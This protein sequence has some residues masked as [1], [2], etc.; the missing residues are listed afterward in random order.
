MPSHRAG[1]LLAAVVVGVCLP[2][3]FAAPAA[4]DVVSDVQA[5][6]HV[7]T[8]Q[9]Y[10]SGVAV[11]DL[12]T[13][14]YSGG[15]EDTA[16]FASESVAKVLI[17]TQLLATGQM[18][19]ATEATAY[20]M[21]TQSDDDAASALYGLAGGD[22]VINLVAA[23]YQIPLLGTPPDQSGWWGNTEITA[24]GMVYLYA[25]IARDPSVGPWLMNAMA[26]ASEYGADGT[27]Q[28]FGIPSATTGAAIKQGWGDDG[29]DSPN[30]VFNSTGFVDNDEY[31]V[32]ILTDGSPWTYGAAISSVVTQ[33]AQA[34][35]PGGRIDNPADHDPVLSPVTVTASG[36][37]VHL[38]GTAVDPDAPSA[39][40]PVRVT[41]GGRTIVTTT[42]TAATRR[43]NADFAASDGTHTYTVTVGNLSD[44]TAVSHATAPVSI[45]GDP[46][47][48]VNAV[49]GGSGT[50]TIDGQEADPNSPEP[51]L[52]IGVA[53]AQPIV[54]STDDPA[55]QITVPASAGIHEVTVTYLHSSDA[56]N[57]TEGTWAV[58]VGTT[59]R[60]TR[61]LDASAIAALPTL[62][63]GFV[64]GYRWLRRT[65]R[66]ANSSERAT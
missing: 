11:L 50:I 6:A 17:A 44:G 63:L 64:M 48:I 33:Q 28:F 58:T 14:A 15:G 7:A 54:R 10:R 49:T 62:L 57:V 19:G 2:L 59:A 65:R 35:M 38:T 53:G 43:F 45:D 9:G 32:A 20:E 30:A 34:L 27:Y 42:T 66:R 36:N 23:R 56:Q 39:S 5:A 16:P 24:K 55:Y 25:S 51:R 8:D 13:G 60:N 21:I 12:R 18:T 26:H 1:T 4:A 37:M 47:G 46:H 52:E 61:V 31:A 41:E 3:V 40:L 22:D 29:D